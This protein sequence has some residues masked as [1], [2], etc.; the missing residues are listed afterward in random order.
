M[1]SVGLISKNGSGLHRFHTYIMYYFQNMS[2]KSVGFLSM[3]GSSLRRLSPFYSVINQVCSLS[4]LFSLYFDRFLL[5]TTYGTVL[6]TFSPCY[7][8]LKLLYDDWSTYRISFYGI[9]STFAPT[10]VKVVFRLSVSNLLRSL[11]GGVFFDSD[12]LPTKFCENRQQ[13]IWIGHNSTMY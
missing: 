6:Q 13:Y 2:L 7:S 1:K 8:P 3:N 4:T 11:L 10:F 12:W 5:Q 9:V